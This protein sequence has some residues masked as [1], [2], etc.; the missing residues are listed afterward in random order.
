MDSEIII[1]IICLTYVIT[2][3]KINF[4]DKLKLMFLIVLGFISKML[5]AAIFTFLFDNIFIIV[6]L[7]LIVGIFIYLKN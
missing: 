1:V 3:Q 6:P 5:N 2:L 4:N 7:Y